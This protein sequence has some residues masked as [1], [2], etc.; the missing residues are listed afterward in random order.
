MRTLRIVSWTIVGLLI[1]A[2]AGALVYQSVFGGSE[3]SMIADTKMGAP[4]EL[5]D[6]NGDPITEKSLEGQPAAIFFGFTHCPEVC[7]TTLYEM[8][9]WLDRLGEDGESIRAFFVTVDPER[10]TPEM[11]KSYVENFTD[12][13]TGITGDPEKV[14]ELKK[15]WRIYA[16]KVPLEDGDYTMDHTASVLLIDSQG[17][18]KGTIAYGESSDTAVE[19][20]RRLA[21][22]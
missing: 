16:R 17:R 9:N 14:A 12:R 11:M 19:K 21:N 13:I 7:P 6:H 20:L 1:V 5:I 3:R 22:G 15:A 4:F 8:A 10:D 18:F 2:I